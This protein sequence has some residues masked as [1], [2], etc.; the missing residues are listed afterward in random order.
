MKII[1]LLAGLFF[2]QLSYSS[3]TITLISYGNDFESAKQQAFR[4]AIEKVCGIE[5][6]S[7]R[8]QF[9]D[10]VIYDNI[11]THSNCRV[12]DYKILETSNNPYKITIQI[13]VHN[14]KKEDRFFAESN[15]YRFSLNLQESI[16]EYHKEKESGNELIKL[17]FKDYP[18]QAYNITNI[19]DPYITNDQARNLYLV[20]PYKLTWNYNF[21]KS[22]RNI[23]DYVSSNVGNGRIVI[24]AKDPKAILLGKKT[25]HYIND[26]GRYDLIKQQFSNDREFRVLVKVRDNKGN[27][28]IDTCHLPKYKQGSMFYHLNYNGNLT[29][30]GNDEDYD[31]ILI[32]INIPLSS[33]FDVNVSIAAAKDCKV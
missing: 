6:L 4:T 32:K 10:K 8:E 17:A 13:H 9:N 20:V 33:I 30:F 22:L 26:Y 7:K 11:A 5:V 14:T 2:S 3:E 28:V 27:I 31:N 15:D 19:K 18:Y 29:I 1:V 25:V 21:I 23:F 24:M 16:D 12:T